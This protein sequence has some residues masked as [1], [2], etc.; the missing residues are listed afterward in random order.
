MLYE[1]QISTSLS[2][3]TAHSVRSREAQTMQGIFQQ[4]S[5]VLA[6][7]TVPYLWSYSVQGSQDL[8][9][10]NSLLQQK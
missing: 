9:S 5:S 7:K 10:E 4:V 1:T 2:S 8:V 6:F 3:Q